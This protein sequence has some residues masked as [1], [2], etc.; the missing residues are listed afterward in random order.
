[1]V[2]ASGEVVLV[3]SADGPE[4]AKHANLVV[5]TSPTCGSCAAGLLSYDEAA[6]AWICR[7]CGAATAVTDPR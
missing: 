7:D 5:T 2:L 6:G 3:M 1:M 4:H